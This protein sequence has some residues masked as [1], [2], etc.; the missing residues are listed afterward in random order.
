MS[1]RAIGAARHPSRRRDAGMTLPEL[2]ISVTMIGIIATVLAASITVT[3]RQ[4]DN[5][6]G[7]LNVARGEQNVDMYLPND[8]A[9]AE[10]LD[11]DPDASPCGAACPPG[12]GLTGSNA[13]M[14]SWTTS[15]SN[16]TSPVTVTTNVSY[17]FSE[18]DEPGIYQ[19][20]RI[21]CRSSGSGWTC[22]SQRVLSGVE[23][24]T[25]WAPGDPV[26]ESIIQVSE[27]LAPDA[28]SEDQ[29]ASA[30]QKKDA[31]RVVVTINGGGDADGAGGGL[32]RISITAGGTSRSTIAADSM[33]NAPTFTEARSRCGGPIAL[34]VDDSGSIGGAMGTVEDGVETFVETFAGTPTKIQ[35]VRFDTTAGVVGAGGQWSRYFDMTDPAQVSS[36]LSAIGPALDDDGGT[37]WEDAWFRAV[38]QQNGQDLA[39]IQPE[40]AIFFTDGEPTYERLR[41]R[42][43]GGG[44]IPGQPMPGPGWPQYSGGHY[45][46]GSDYSQVAFNRAKWIVDQIRG[47]TRVI[48]V[49][50]G[51]KFESGTSKWIDSPGRG[52]HWEYQRGYRQYQQAPRVYEVVATYQSNLDTEKATSFESTRR[53]ESRVDFEVRSWFWWNDATPAQYLAA[54]ASDR[55]IQGTRSWYTVT[56]AEYDALS[57]NDGNWRITTGG[58]TWTA[59]TEAMYDANNVNSGQNDGWRISG[60]ENVQPGDYYPNASNHK[61][62]MNGTRSWYDVSKAE[63]T[64]YRS[65]SPSNWRPGQW[66]STSQADYEANNTTP[67]ESDGYRMSVGSWRWITKAEYD[68]GNDPAANPADSDGFRDAGKQYV[69]DDD[70]AMDWEPSGTTYTG[71]GYRRIQSFTEPYD[72]FEEA[73]SSWVSNRDIL[74]TLVTGNSGAVEWNEQVPGNAKVADLFVLDDYDNFAQAL[75]S[76]ALAECGGTLTVSTRVGST[77]AADPFTYQNSKVFNSSGADLEVQPTVVTTSSTFPTGTFDFEIPDGSYVT[78]EL[79]PHN[80]S[81]LTGYSPVGW[82]C[83]S[84]ITPIT[85]LEFPPVNDVEYPG[86]TG[87]RVRVA[88]NQAVSCTLNVTR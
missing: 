55:R 13:L 50:V 23:L 70:D 30:S 80:L 40:L 47:S 33:L 21:E 42:A 36:L 35:I 19:L 1:D 6:E 27:P 83:K 2:L 86:W 75:Q 45:S 20:V 85:G 74:A 88:A 87:V 25:N 4:A 62:R 82:S 69:N 26:P 16:G 84:G 31:N 34:I 7:R 68:A 49:G 60:W 81:D 76:V 22:D 38:Y 28:V 79:M 65:L 67:D 58:S 63:Y 54:S 78:V 56:G 15:T 32:N 37:N 39:Q 53:Y 61:Y 29:I 3:F 46:N 57:T 9:S 48:G 17:H 52:W 73:K 11:Q 8:L 12:L 24:L 64:S 43:S 5:T 51:S 66:A 77:R 41:Y 44:D 59:V 72:S 14:V 10:T 71:G 18:T